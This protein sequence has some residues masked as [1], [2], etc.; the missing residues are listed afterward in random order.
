MSSISLSSRGFSQ[1][2]GAGV[3]VKMFWN[4]SS[5]LLAS[6]ADVSIK[7][8]WFS[9]V[10]V[11]VS[12]CAI[13]LDVWG[14]RTSKRLGLLGWDSPQ[15]PQIALVSDKHDDDIGIGVIP[16]LLQPSR[17]VL[18]GL[19]LAD[20]VDEEGTNSASVVG[21]CNGAVSLLTGGIP[22]LSLDRLGI[23]L[24]GSG[25]ELDTDSRLGV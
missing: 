4:A 2:G 9:P 19:V 1:G 14:F 16:Q 8:K 7:D 5:T 15:V 25:G 22:N 6:R 12:T 21:G 17:D 24:D 23:D 11:F 10:K 3:P 18:V 20:V 13:Q